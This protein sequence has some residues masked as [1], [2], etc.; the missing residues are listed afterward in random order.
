MERGKASVLFS[1]TLTPLDYF[2]SVLGGDENSKRLTLASPFPQENLCLLV[3]DR[4]S[5]KYKDRQDS[6][7]PVA[8][9]IA[10]TVSGK[11]GN[12]L[13]YFPSYAYLREVYQ[14]FQER[15]PAVATIV[16][17]SEMCIRDRLSA[18]LLPMYA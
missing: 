15:Y 9:Q 16:Q 1:A 10:L 7:V 8:D 6:L 18:A 3:S 4:I 2:I 17:R 13:A 14:V 11:K 5:T 12:Y